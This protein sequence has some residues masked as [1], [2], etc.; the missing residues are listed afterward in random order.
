M[1][2]LLQNLHSK[3][4]RLF[5]IEARHSWSWQVEEFEFGKRHDLPKVIQKYYDY[6]FQA[7]RRFNRNLPENERITVR[8]LDVNHVAEAFNQ[9][10]QRMPVN[11][12]GDTVFTKILGLAGTEKKYRD[13]LDKIL[14]ILH[15]NTALYE[16]K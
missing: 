15:K 7:L 1:S 9:S 10:L 14:Q 6:Q 2:T 12:S 16:A 5:L 13:E 4:F 11:I 3:N 8:C